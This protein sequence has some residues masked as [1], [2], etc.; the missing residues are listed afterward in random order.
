MGKC[1]TLAIAAAEKLRVVQANVAL[2]S[3]PRID[4]GGERYSDDVHQR[5][6]RDVGGKKGRAIAADS[7]P[8]RTN[9]QSVSLEVARCGP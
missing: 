1:R 8:C 3:T 4:I 9:L 7:K 5:I 6:A 2:H